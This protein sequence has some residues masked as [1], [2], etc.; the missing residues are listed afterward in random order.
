MTY[1]SQRITVICEQC[2]Q[3]FSLSSNEL[4]QHSQSHQLTCQHCHEPVMMKETIGQKIVRSSLNIAFVINIIVF[5]SIISSHMLYEIGLPISIALLCVIIHLL[6]MFVF[7]PQS[8]KLIA[9]VK[10]PTFLH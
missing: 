7:K 4:H 9:A 8:I 2:Y 6:V 10:P 5:A 3:E 1:L